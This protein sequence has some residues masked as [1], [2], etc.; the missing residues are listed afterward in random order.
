MRPAIPD[1]IRPRPMNATF[2]TDPRK[3]EK[4]EE[5]EK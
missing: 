4:V 1:P 3:V 2:M 5:M